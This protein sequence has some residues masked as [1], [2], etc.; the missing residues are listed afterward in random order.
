MHVHGT[1]S[2]IHA[3]RLHQLFQGTGA[4]VQGSFS[5]MHRYIL[6]R[7]TCY[8]DMVWP[9]RSVV[10]VEE[11]YCCTISNHIFW[12]KDLNVFSMQDLTILR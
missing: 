4:M 8:I 3:C 6:L 10:D 7:V 2:D 12:S 11:N 9:L 1:W 5:I